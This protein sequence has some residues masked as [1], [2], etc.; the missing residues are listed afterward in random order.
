MH[1][2]ALEL[3]ERRQIRK[4]GLELHLQQLAVGGRDGVVGAAEHALFVAQVNALA[5]DVGE[6]D[7]AERVAHL[8]VLAERDLVGAA[9][10][11]HDVGGMERLARGHL[12]RMDGVGTLSLRRAPVLDHQIP[13]DAHARLEAH[14]VLVRICGRGHGASE[15][16]QAHV[17]CRLNGDAQQHAQV[18]GR[19]ASVEDHEQRGL[20]RCERSEAEGAIRRERT[21]GKRQPL[22]RHIVAAILES[23]DGDKFGRG[24]ASE[25]AALPR[26]E[27]QAEAQHHE[28]GMCTMRA[29][30]T[31]TADIE[32]VDE[33]VGDE[34]GRDDALCQGEDLDALVER[35]GRRKVG[36]GCIRRDLGVGDVVDLLGHSLAVARLGDA[37]IGGGELF[38]RGERRFGLA[39]QLVVVRVK[40]SSGRAGVVARMAV[41]EVGRSGCLEPRELV[42][43]M[44]EGIERLS[45]SRWLEED[46]AGRG[47]ELRR[48]WRAIMSSSSLTRLRSAAISSSGPEDE[49]ALIL[50]RFL[51]RGILAS[52]RQSSWT[53]FAMH[54]LHGRLV[55]HLSFFWRQREQ[56]GVK[57]WMLASWCCCS[58]TSWCAGRCTLAGETGR[59]LLC[60]VRCRG[61][62]RSRVRRHHGS[63]FL[64]G[65]FALEGGMVRVVRVERIMSWVS[66][67]LVLLVVAGM[68]AIMVE[69]L[70]GVAKRAAQRRRTPAAAW[71][72]RRGRLGPACLCL[73]CQW[74]GRREQR[75][76]SS[77]AVWWTRR[78]VAP[79]RRLGRDSGESEGQWRTGGLAARRLH[80]ESSRAQQHS[81]RARRGC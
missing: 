72:D 53:P 49:V 67:V 61:D 70:I 33:G 48:F 34:L 7:L 66:V 5:D 68:A 57:R 58:G 28:L 52:L 3:V 69:L 19:V 71:G 31:V 50:G 32:S 75:E 38:E 80:G 17:E 8:A 60:R 30:P 51:P 62:V 11:E 37:R 20:D 9:R 43:S 78:K 25:R 44:C 15:A 39:G 73:C 23:V 16:V 77:D 1:G 36:V 6:A 81:S 35:R 76:R 10:G 46:E 13:P 59:R 56:E 21:L 63:V 4:E 41:V 45:E 40:G 24:V 54:W 14:N 22:A 65:V 64:V 55:S 79:R 12:R 27:T 2:V 74:H 42:P 47:E 29:H 26:V 18:A